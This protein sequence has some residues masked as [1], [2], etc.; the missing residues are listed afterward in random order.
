MSLIL[1]P[2]RASVGG[3]RQ[4]T[5]KATVRWAW[6]ISSLSLSSYLKRNRWPHFPCSGIARP[7][8]HHHRRLCPSSLNRLAEG[9]AAM[10]STRGCSKTASSA[11]WVPWTTTYRRWWSRSFSSSSQSPARNQSTCTST[12]LAVS[13]DNYVFLLFYILMT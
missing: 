1:N 5:F 6:Y 2:I 13:S 9:S 7:G 10:T 12:V 8:D 3:C 4:M 11:S